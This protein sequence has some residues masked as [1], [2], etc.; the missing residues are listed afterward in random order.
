MLF[1][2]EPH[3]DQE[4]CNAIGQIPLPANK[5]LW[6]ATSPE[7]WEKAHTAWAETRNGRPPLTYG[8]MVILQQNGRS[9]DDPRWEDLD[10]WYLNLDAFGTFVLMAATSI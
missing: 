2:V 10:D 4:A 5:S 1:N 6:E 3:A 8:D 9:S 7:E